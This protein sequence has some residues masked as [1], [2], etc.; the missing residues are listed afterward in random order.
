MAL[1]RVLAGG[2]GSRLAL[3]TERRADLIRGYR[4]DVLVVLSADAVYRLDY[5]MVA[6]AHLGSGADGVGV[7]AGAIVGG[8]GELALVGRR[9]EV[10]RDGHVPA[11][12]RYPEPEEGR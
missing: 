12:G 6:D 11:G 10:E 8:D 5:R 7:G 2:A 9:A 4:A 1:P 3:L